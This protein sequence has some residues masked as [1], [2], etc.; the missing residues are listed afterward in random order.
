MKRRVR[1]RTKQ[2]E[3]DESESKEGKRMS[4][5]KRRDRIS[6]FRY[7]QG[8]AVRKK[9]SGKQKSKGKLMDCGERKKYKK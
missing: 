6:N 1:T 2:G 7:I 9:N 5:R 8:R 4:G 3:E